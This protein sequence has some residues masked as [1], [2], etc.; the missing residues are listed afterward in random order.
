MKLGDLVNQVKRECRYGTS[1]LNTDQQTVDILA[2]A[3]TSLKEIW[4][5]WDWPWALEKIS[6]AVNP[7]AT[8]YLV[9]S[10]S[11]NLVDRITD[12]IPQDP[13]TAPATWGA[14]LQEM[15]RQEF[16]AWFAQQVPASANNSAPGV[17]TKYVNLGLDPAGSGLW[18]IEIAPLPATGFLMKG[19]AKKLL[20]TPLIQ[21]VIANNAIPYFPDGVIDYCLLDGIKAGVYEIQG[22]AAQAQAFDASFQRKIQ[23]KI[24][25]QSN[26]GRDDSG[27]TVPPPD[28]WRWRQRMRAQRGTGVY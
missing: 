21:D 28:S 25:E 4:S 9:A 19:F 6:F 27:I 2:R 22:S 26:A 13:T 7:N 15:E 14:P 16:Y 17:P 20:V 18:Q 10:A 3:V 23:K 11:G 12:L 8:Q 5:A 24:A 1:G